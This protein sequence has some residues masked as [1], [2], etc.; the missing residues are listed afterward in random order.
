MEPR[1]GIRLPPVQF[2]AQIAIV[3][4]TGVQ[5]LDDLFHH[6][7][8]CCNISRRGEHNSSQRYLKFYNLI[9]SVIHPTIVLENKPEGGTTD[10]NL[11]ATFRIDG[12]FRLP[13]F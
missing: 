13:L 10:G 2:K 3:G 8:F 4:D 11:D 12:D 7:S 1:V 6:L 5:L 9:P